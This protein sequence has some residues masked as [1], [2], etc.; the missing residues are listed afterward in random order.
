MAEPI[1][2]LLFDALIAAARLPLT[3]EEAERARAVS[4]YVVAYGR[5]LGAPDPLT[6]DPATT[7]RAE[8]VGR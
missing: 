3:P 4:R 6:T 2:K 1:P 7:F 5:S 8:S